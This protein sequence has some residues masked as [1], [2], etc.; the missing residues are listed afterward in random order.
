M[1]YIMVLPKKYNILIEV[2]MVMQY[3]T[4]LTI[5]GFYFLLV[6]IYRE[7]YYRYSGQWPREE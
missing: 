4:I 6:E 3:L 5:L 7:I 1:G 2:V